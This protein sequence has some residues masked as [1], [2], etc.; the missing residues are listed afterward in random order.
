MAYE[1][2]DYA[3]QL[4]EAKTVAEVQQIAEDLLYHDTEF[5]VYNMSF[6]NKKIASLIENKQ[7]QNY[8]VVHFDMHRF[9]AVNRQVGR[10]VGTEVMKKYVRRLQ[11]LLGERGYVGHVGGDNFIALFLKDDFEEVR[12]FLK[13]MKVSYSDDV[14]DDVWLS[15]CAGYY[16]LSENCG[17][18]NEIMDRVSLAVHKAKTDPDLREVFVDDEL[19]DKQNNVKLIETMFEQAL[20]VDEIQVYY[21]PKVQLNGYR[22]AGAE[23][24]SRWFH[25][26][27][28]IMP[29]KFIP[30]LEQ[31]QSICDLD[32]YVLRRVCEDI[33]RWLDEGKKVVRVSVNLSRRNLDNPGLVED[34]MDTI[35]SYQV[36]HELIEIELT[37]TTTDVNFMDLRKVV[38]ALHEEG[39]STS[40]DDFGMG[41]SSLNL[42]RELPWNVLKIDRSYLPASNDEE[43]S[44][45]HIMLKHLIAMSQDMGLECI[46]EG[47]EN[48]DQIKLLK[49]NHCFLAQG[50]YFDKPLP[51]SEF[52]K[53]L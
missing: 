19:L 13:G 25:D 35:D 2:E 7:I 34:I 5:G 39:I 37:E 40:V 22:L 51:V 52:E 21:Q 32:F 3:A 31:S 48:V 42:I 30:I 11:K 4:S 16:C 45:E 8:V 14:G 12:K 1:V 49:K 23:A 27:E 43:K 15:T 46:V 24:L 20:A 36:P 26:G 28:L 10:S 6:L 9:T 17:T 44:N 18:V 41:Y 29:A 47:V 33:R 53:K 38:E 50:F